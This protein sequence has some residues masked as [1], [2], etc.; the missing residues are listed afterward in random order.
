M[1]QPQVLRRVVSKLRGRSSCIA[2]QSRVDNTGQFRIDTTYQSP[3]DKCGFGV[4]HVPH[5]SSKYSHSMRD[6][7]FDSCGHFVGPLSGAP[8][9]SMVPAQWNVR[10][11]RKELAKASLSA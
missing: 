4:W 8:S 10:S 5:L 3:G 7:C 6:Y 2:Y 11:D 9:E 1:Q